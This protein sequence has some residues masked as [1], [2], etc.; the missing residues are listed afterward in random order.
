[1]PKSVHFSSE[2]L[3]KYLEA[4]EDEFLEDLKIFLRL[5]SI[6]ASYEHQGDCSVRVEVEQLL[7]RLCG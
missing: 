5:P 3:A 2:S 4:Q 1:M 6:S 7:G